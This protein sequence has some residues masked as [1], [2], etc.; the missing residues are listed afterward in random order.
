M[1]FQLAGLASGFDWRSMIDQL[2]AVERIPQQRLREDQSDNTEMRDALDLL[3]SKMDNLKSSMGT[4]DDSALYNAKT[5]SLSDDTLGIVADASTSAV[6]GNYEFSVTQLATTSKRSGTTDVGGSLGSANTVISNL[7]FAQDI[8]EGTVTI[9]G[10]EITVQSTDTLQD[11]FDS[12]SIATSGVVTAAYDNVADKVTLTS[13]SGELELGETAD[14]SNFLS[15]L[16]LDQ[17]EVVDAGGGSSAVTSTGAL[18]VLDLSS[19]IASSG[20]SPAVSGSGTITINGVAVSFD[21]DN[22]SIGSLMGKVNDSAANVTMTYDTAA[23][24]FRIVNKETGALQMPVI[25]SANGILAAIGLDG[26]ATVGQDLQFSVDGG[27]AVSSRSNVIKESAHGITGLTITSTETGTQTIGIGRDSEELRE[28]I[29]EFIASYNDVQDFILEKTKVTVEGDDVKTS[30]LSGNRE[31][32]SLD[33][34]L[35][36]TAFAA[37]DNLGGDLFRLEHMGIDFIQDTSKLEIKNADALDEALTSQ[38]DQL[39][40]FFMGDT[41]GDGDIEESFATRMESFVENYTRDDGILDVQIENLT[42]RNQDIDERIEEME[43]RLEFTR[44]SLESSFIAMEEAQ[45]NIQQ[46]G[47]ALAGLQV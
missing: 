10:Q 47:S 33:S 15:V 17:I 12:I 19:S 25:D 42:N 28:K 23:D 46:Q 16:K 40:Q 8:N 37:I 5:A 21:A 3:E 31:V 11:V 45:S 7:R 39:E 22:E 1:Q 35:R 43:R 32:Y 4:F 26:G 41:D 9:N 18:G 34:K 38:L 27:P 30:V 2:M 24:Q 6:E 36:A 14:T 20:L 44:S 29:N 13:S